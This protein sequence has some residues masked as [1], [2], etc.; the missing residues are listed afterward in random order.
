MV[1][2]SLAIFVSAFLLFLVQ[3]LIGKFI[4]PWFGGTPAVWST[5]MVFFQVVLLG[6]YAYAHL[7][8]QRLAAR[9]QVMVHLALLAGALILLVNFPPAASWKPASPERPVGQILL[10][11]T[12]CLGLPYLA[13]SAT[14]PL[15][16][17]W[18]SRLF[19]ATSPYRLY[20]LSNVGSLLALI[21]YPF[22]LEP[23]YPRP[24]QAAL[25]S[26]GFAMFAFL[27]A[28][29]AVM[30]WRRA[31]GA[32]GQGAGRSPVEGP[33]PIPTWRERV[34]WLALPASASVML[35]AVTNKICQDIAV[36]PFL[37]VLPLSLYLIT[38]I[39]CFDSPRWYLR[40][41]FGVLLVPGVAATAW[42]L[43]EFHSKSVQVQV[44]IYVGTMFVCC[45][46][47]HGETVRLKPHPRHLTEFYLMIAAGGAL[48]GIF[49][50]LVAPAIF[51]GFY[52]LHLGLVL[53]AAL[54]LVV[55]ATDARSPFR[56]G[57]GLWAWCGF[58]PGF[59]ALGVVLGFAVRHEIED[60]L[61]SKRNF[62]GLLRVIEYDVES[63]ESN[64]LLLQHGGTTHGLQ[65]TSPGRRMT[66][67]TYY[68]PGS[69]VGLVMN[70]FRTNA[71]RH[72]GLVGLGTGTLAA[73]GRKGDGFRIY[74]INPVVVELA[75]PRGTSFSFVSNSA[76][77]VQ[78]VLGDARLSME[79]EADQ[80]FDVLAL[81]AF[82]S[83]A[84]PV[85][86]LTRE[87]F[88]IYLRHLKPDGVLAVHISNR[89]LDLEPVVM[90]LVEHFN[91]YA[92]IIDREEEELEE[93]AGAYT[94]AYGSTWVLISRSD[95]FLKS[96]EI[97]SLA[98]E[99]DPSLRHR[100][101]WTDDDSN[102]FDILR[103]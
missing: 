41:V 56:R 77:H 36:I 32:A 85:H 14:G 5:C 30:L 84:I 40:S 87:A 47:M 83:D 28:W 44:P 100:R 101:L 38:F 15:L 96:S 43:W 10:M 97:R 80:H 4:L 59:A 63:P 68:V 74:E 89:Y 73:Y 39:I 25:W 23:H 53:C 13:L 17:A 90:T 18:F 34:L 52:E 79:R 103:Y 3:P 9:R 95:T 29:C 8:I 92:E 31:G 2:Y 1:A 72:V 11:L 27:C 50:A 60:T 16:Q 48:G 99:T 26:W 76:A 66:P 98:S 33:A 88:E 45:M 65:F 91:L 78:I 57:R 102:L 51:N 22:L 49:V 21:G 20:A 35:L 42:L 71:P 6:G 54:F 70:H 12:V 55:L 94:G 24:T 93:D 69:G 82:S 7:L 61:L 67:T 81:D 37:W 62:Y 58:G 46:V 86:L 64:R 75:G 19:P